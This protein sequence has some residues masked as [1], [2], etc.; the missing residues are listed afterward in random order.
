MYKISENIFF[1]GMHTEIIT[2]VRSYDSLF[3][4]RISYNLVIRCDRCD[5]FRTDVIDVTC[6]KVGPCNPCE[7]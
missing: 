6:I 7:S 2:S 5:V 4:K 3:R 1:A